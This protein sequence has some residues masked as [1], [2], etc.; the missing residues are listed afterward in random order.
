MI[1][2]I[3]IMIRCCLP[4]LAVSERPSE[5][6][7]PASTSQTDSAARGGNSPSDDSVSASSTLYKPEW[8]Q[9]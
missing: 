1:C 9:P 8:N 6:H 5:S 3:C 2:M 4:S 7:T